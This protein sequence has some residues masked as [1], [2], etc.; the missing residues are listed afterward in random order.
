MCVC[1]PIKGGNTDNNNNRERLWSWFF[2]FYIP[3]NPFLVY[4]CTFFFL[5]SLETLLFHFNS[6]TYCVK[7]SWSSGCTFEYVNM[8]WIAFNVTV[9][10]CLISSVNSR[11]CVQLPCQLNMGSDAVCC[12]DSR[13]KD[14]DQRQKQTQ[15][16]PQYYFFSRQKP[17]RETRHVAHIIIFSFL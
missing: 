4:T 14:N 17:V 10:T 8:R 1:T 5:G 3:L 7:H 13:K 11:E 2:F 6:K 15:S 9:L 16:R 12:A